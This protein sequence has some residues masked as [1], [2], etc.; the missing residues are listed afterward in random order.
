MQT[1]N[2]D[3]EFMLVLKVMVISLPYIFQV[4]Y[5]LCFTNDKISGERLQD[6]WSSGCMGLRTLHSL[7][8]QLCSTLHRSKQKK[9]YVS[10][11]FSESGCFSSISS[12]LMIYSLVSF[13]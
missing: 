9:A 4:L 13:V 1:T 10:C 7:K 11:Y 8:F 5:V 2:C 6:Q 12:K 3:Y